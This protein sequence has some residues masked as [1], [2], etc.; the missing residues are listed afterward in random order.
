MKFLYVVWR[1]ITEYYHT[2]RTL[3]C[4]LIA[5]V[6]LSTVFVTGIY[7][8]A[9][10]KVFLPQ[11]EEQIYRNIIIGE[12]EDKFQDDAEVFE[13]LDICSA[14]CD[15]EYVRFNES[16][17]K[18]LSNDFSCV[19][20]SSTDLY[21]TDRYIKHGRVFFETDETEKDSAVCI[22]LTNVKEPPVG[23]GDSI[24]IYG[25]ECTVIG[26]LKYIFRSS[27]KDIDCAIMPLRSFIALAGYPSIIS[28]VFKGQIGL[29]N[30]NRLIGIIKDRWP[31]I[32]VQPSAQF[33]IAQ[34]YN[35]QAAVIFIF[36][37][38]NLAALSLMVNYFDEKN[39]ANDSALRLAGAERGE[40]VL[41]SFVTRCAVVL[42]TVIVTLAVVWVI[43]SELPG[44]I[45]FA[46][47]TLKY[48][49][50]DFAAIFA[51]FFVSTCIAMMPYTIRL[52]ARS[53]KDFASKRE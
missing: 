44:K 40:I 14:F 12:C 25:R 53:A 49:F 16:N 2:G 6:V 17:Q 18:T 19:G 45:S 30:E 29:E 50:S 38:F 51:M 34:D 13:L 5:A 4:L 22:Y 43:T 33:T 9:V 24:E 28:L 31:G 37:L 52:Y 36:I 26:T 32:F 3:F 35:M 15:L 41:Y 1:R 8:L 7:G 47:K 46:D 11:S 20:V 27:G 48:S 42:F 39:V 10:E 23:I 21:N